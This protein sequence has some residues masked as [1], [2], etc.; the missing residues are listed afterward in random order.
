MAR[1]YGV[2][3]ATCGMNIPLFACKPKE[4]RDSSIYRV[5]QESLSCRECG[6]S[7]IYD[8]EDSLFFDGPEGLAL[9]LPT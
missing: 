5:P 6:G 9:F 3:C 1:Y 7:H 8:S 2:K 4:G